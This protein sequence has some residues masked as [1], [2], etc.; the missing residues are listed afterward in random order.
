MEEA[1]DLSFDAL[2]MMMMMMMMIAVIT[3]LYYQDYITY[4][5]HVSVN[6]AV[7]I[8]RLDTIYQRS[9]IDMM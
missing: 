5:L 7:V 3:Q 2:L 6:A 9:Y 4:Q 8:I 1:L